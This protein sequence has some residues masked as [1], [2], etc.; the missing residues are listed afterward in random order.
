MASTV[1]VADEFS[2]DAQS[3]GALHG[4]ARGNRN[5]ERRLAAMER[6][7]P[8]SG[9]RL[10]DAGCGTGEYT[11]V[12]APAFE[13]VDGIE[14]EQRR[15]EMFKETA[16]E[17]ITLQMMS[18]NQLDFEDDTFDRIVLIEVLEHLTDIA[19]A[20]KEI[21]RVLTPEGRVLLTT[22]SRRWPLEQ[23]GVLIGGSRR[24]SYGAPGR[25]WITPRQAT[26]APS[27]R[28]TSPATPSRPGW[29]STA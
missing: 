28:G 29:S 20:M 23:H 14:I 16:P 6:L 15:L 5:V 4:S 24:P 18:V 25:E 26:P 3:I 9:T 10:L 2:S 12:M 7:A 1:Q 13:S 11:T 21:A 22:P 19:G 27:S 8:L 17:G